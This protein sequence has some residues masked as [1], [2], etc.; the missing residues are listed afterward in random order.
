MINFD[1]LMES[2]ILCCIAIIAW[3]SLLYIGVVLIE[4]LKKV[5]SNS[6]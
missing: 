3:M 5:I 4:F 1:L 6:K 2:M